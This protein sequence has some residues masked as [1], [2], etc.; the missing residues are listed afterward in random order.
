[1]LKRTRLKIPTEAGKTALLEITPE[2]ISNFLYWV[3]SKI[4]S[5]GI[6]VFFLT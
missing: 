3:N 6:Y 1:M 2:F 5:D 4:A